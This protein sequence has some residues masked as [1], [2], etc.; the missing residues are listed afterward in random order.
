MKSQES[1]TKWREESDKMDGRID[2]V[3]VQTTEWDKMQ[4]ENNNGQK[5]E[6]KQSD[7]ITLPQKDK[8]KT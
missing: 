7:I 3:P 5:D 8:G 6:G 4:I 2:C 1:L